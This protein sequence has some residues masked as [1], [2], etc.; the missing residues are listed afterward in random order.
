MRNGRVVLGFLALTLL[1][2]WPLG[3]DPASSVLG[4]SPDTDLFIWTLAWDTHALTSGLLSIF[5]ANIYYPQRLTLAYSEN[6]IGDLIVAA[7]VLWAT[8]NPVLAMNVV[9]LASCLL[10]GV[11]AYVL[12]RRVGA[13]SPAAF[14]TGVVFAFAPPRFLRISQLHLTAV[15]WLPFALAFLH[16]YLDEGRRRDLRLAIGCF[17]LQA[18]SSGHGA[19]FTATA[20]LGLLVYRVA[21]GE[22]FAVP[23]RVRDTG[24]AGLA[25][26]A[27]TVLL[28][29]PYLVVQRE[30]GLRRSLEDWA[31]PASTFLASPTYVHRFLLSLA[32]ASSVNEDALAWLFP[33]Y[34][35]VA[36]AGVALVLRDPRLC[37]AVP[38]RRANNWMRLAL[39]L[40]IAALGLLAVAVAATVV[41]PFRWRIGETVVLSVRQ[42]IRVWSQFA[43]V[44]LVRW[45]LKGRAPFA[46]A[47]RAAEWS[48]GMAR[49][50]ARRRGDVRT[51]YALLTL[52]AFW[53]SIG[54]PLGVWPLVYWLPGLNL[55]RVPSRFTI[56][57]MLGLAVLAGLGFDRLTSHR[58]PA[59]ARAWAWV[60][61]A[62][63]IAEFA[64]FPLATVPYRVEIPAIDRWL[65]SRTKPFA[66]AEVPLPSYGAG[67]AWERRQSEYMLH[68]MA[69]W[70]KTVH[71]YSGMRPPLHEALYWQ[72]RVFPDEQSVAAL[73][74]LGVTYVV[75]HTDLYPEGEWPEIETRLERFR[76]VLHLEHVE[77]SGRVYSLRPTLNA[78]R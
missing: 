48:A 60:A 43:A 44:A 12:A 8:G 70:Q 57:G 45:S 7:P 67:G 64:L 29:G 39:V 14:L 65:D 72:L 18:L 49:W 2:S 17:T 10:C 32:S 52:L 28:F 9:A 54:P 68:S 5:D 56:L 69:H 25:L 30:M 77:G 27:P 6:L 21:L 66:V 71:G 4:R 19:V 55:I 46:V 47:V 22:P 59:W 51:F 20:L 15:Q 62:A 11:G 58:S 78:E 76:D 61:G 16:A 40:E 24:V 38:V 3:R 75:V 34:L 37:P 73:Q 1:M 41:G 35:P 33:G 63:M 23:K 26:L 31:V 36:L 50:A 13:G 53:L 42:P 74:T